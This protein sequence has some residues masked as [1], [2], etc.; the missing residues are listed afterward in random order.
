MFDLSDKRAMN[1]GFGDGMTRAVEFA[2]SPLLLG[3]IG[4]LLDRSL[5]TA[6]FLAVAFAAFGFAGTLVRAWYGY[7]HE[8]RGIEAQGRW[9]RTRT[10]EP[11]P[12]DEIVDLWATRKAAGTDGGVR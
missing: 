9:N 1:K 10:V 11:S 5:G 7:D 3:L 4:H 6:P 8:M 2:F 12:A